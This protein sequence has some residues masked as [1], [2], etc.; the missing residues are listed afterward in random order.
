MVLSYR[1]YTSRYV[2]TRVKTRGKCHLAFCRLAVI[3]RYYVI[4]VL[5]Y[6]YLSSCIFHWR[7]K[8]CEWKPTQ[9]LSENPT[10]H[11]TVRLEDQTD[12]CVGGQ[13]PIV[14][15]ECSMEDPS[16]SP[17]PEEKHSY[18]DYDRYATLHADTSA[19]GWLSFPKRV[20]VFPTRPPTG[21]CGLPFAELLFWWTH[22]TFTQTEY[23]VFWTGMNAVILSRTPD[24]CT[25]DPIVNFWSLTT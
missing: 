10:P 7:R 1:G 24:T 17:T 14:I 8:H 18:Q 3:Q 11:D 22:A 16:L 19:R 12:R 20:S 2:H 5:S 25:R 9:R 21:R 6:S 15:F 4:N 23:F 13:A